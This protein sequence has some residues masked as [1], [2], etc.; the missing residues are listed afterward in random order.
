MKHMNPSKLKNLLALALL[1][2]SASMAA[3]TVI[4]SFE[5]LPVVDPN[6]PPAN[7]PYTNITH[8]SSAGVTD[9]AYSM[10]ID[11]TNAAFAWM[12][13][14]QPSKTD[15]YYPAYGKWYAHR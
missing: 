11:F 1:A 2:L 6:N 13:L 4:E 7:P 14:A 3:A 5:M 8:S 9:G 10:Q 15:A 12:Y